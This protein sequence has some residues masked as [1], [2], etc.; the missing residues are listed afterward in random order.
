MSLEALRLSYDDFV[1]ARDLVDSM[2]EDAAKGHYF[3]IPAEDA[4]L[5]AK[6]IRELE[7]FVN[8]HTPTK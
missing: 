4:H 2:E 6:Y 5:L 1:K 3:E 8:R 7:Q